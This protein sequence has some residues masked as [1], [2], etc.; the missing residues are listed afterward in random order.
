MKGLSGKLNAK[1][2]RGDLEDIAFIPVTQ[3]HKCKNKD[4][5]QGK[6]PLRP[7]QFS[8]HNT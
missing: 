6:T 2:W 5:S 3:I 8:N 1:A 7:P 4:F